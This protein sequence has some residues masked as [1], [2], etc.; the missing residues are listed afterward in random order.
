MKR[1]LFGGNGKDLGEKTVSGGQITGLS[2]AV[3]TACVGLGYSADFLSTKLAYA[4]GMGTALNQVKKV[5]QA[6]IIAK[7]LHAKGL[8]IGPNFDELYDLPPSKGHQLIAD[9]TV[10]SEY[11]LPTFPF[12]GHW[13]SDSRLAMRATAPKPATLLAAVIGIQTNDKA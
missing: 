8:K 13:D 3:T 6:G 10:Y 9:D 7:D 2:E 1:L 4:S 12:G 5:I 11:D